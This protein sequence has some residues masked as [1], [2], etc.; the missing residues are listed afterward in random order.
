MPFPTTLDTLSIALVFRNVGFHAI[1]PQE[2]PCCTRIKAAIGIEIG[3]FVVQSTAF[4]FTEGI[5]EFLI[6]VIAVVM[7]ASY[8]ASRGNYITFCIGYW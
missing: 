6:Q 2:F 1:I 4:H 7:V 5:L 3:T 8:D